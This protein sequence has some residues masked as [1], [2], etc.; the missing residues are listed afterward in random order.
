MIDLESSA[1]LEKKSRL[2]LIDGNAMLHRAYHALP[3]LT[4][5]DGTQVNAVYGFA[6]MLIRLVHDLRPTHMAVTFDRA[7]PTFRKKLYK[8]YQATRPKMDEELVSQI[9]L[10]HELVKS[11]GISIFELDGFEA[12][13]LIGTLCRKIQN[14]NFQTLNKSK[15]QKSNDSNHFQVIV[16]TGDRD[17]LQLVEDEK[18]LVYMPTKGLS[19]GKLYGERE[20][21]ARMGVT[22]KLIPDLKGLMG[23]SSDN[24]PGVA[25]IGPKTAVE[26][27]RV[28]N[29]VE[30]IYKMLGKG[31]N[32]PSPRLRR[33]KGDR[34]N[35]GN[36]GDKSKFSEGVWEKLKN[37]EKDAEV[38]K[39]L[40]TIRKDVQ[41]EVD[42]ESL[43]I[44]SFDTKAA[45]AFLENLHFYSLIKRL[46]GPED[47]DDK[48]V[49]KVRS[50]A[51]KPIAIVEQL[52]LV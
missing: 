9:D 39:N 48:K 25:G 3:P 22:P 15:T 8:E 50:V 33:A 13:D 51:K 7:A 30:G 11:F 37:G 12:D 27:L 28:F 18:V 10:V 44:G 34:E 19:E 16:V 41:L 52:E 5:P 17:I 23:D 4:S 29:S 46:S 32:P 49:K 21:E 1:H 47:E 42:P 24:Y 31:D 38:S 14:P 36:K 2:I 35:R 43:A 26:L 20:V 45:H 6:S 40:A